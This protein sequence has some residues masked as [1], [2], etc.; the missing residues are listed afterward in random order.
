MISV[1]TKKQIDGLELSPKRP[2]IICDVD[3][4]VVHFIA[5]LEAFLLTQN[6]WL[7][8]ASFALNGNIKEKSNNQPVCKEQVAD[9]LARFFRDCSRS[10][11][12]IEG[13]AETLHE[14]SDDASI[15]FL[16]NFPHENYHERRTNLDSHGL[17]FP[18]ITN[19]GPKGPAIA[20]ICREISAP[21][22]FI[23]D[24]PHYLRSAAEHFAPINLIHFTQDQRFARHLPP[25][26]IDHFRC[27]TW[28]DIKLHIMNQLRRATP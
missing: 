1:E 27:E 28:L 19:Q 16:T 7:D 25:L 21:V 11:A 17:A 2:L 18:L 15:I 23:D 9:L 12:M 5:G 3:E 24:I 8:T 14:L 22:F 6:L 20:H 4:V 13:T 10:L 26:E